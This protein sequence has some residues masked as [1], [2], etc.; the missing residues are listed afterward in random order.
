MAVGKTD[1][2]RNLFF[3]KGTRDYIPELLLMLCE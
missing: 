2:R 1:A 3:V